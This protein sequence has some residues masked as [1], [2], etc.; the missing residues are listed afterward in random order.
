MEAKCNLI[1]PT[2][3][4]E[5]CRFWIEEAGKKYHLFFQFA[6]VVFTTGICFFLEGRCK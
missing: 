4:R 3:L 5:S 6:P 1:Y 2:A